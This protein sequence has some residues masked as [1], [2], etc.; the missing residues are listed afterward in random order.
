MTVQGLRVVALTA[1]EKRHALRIMLERERLLS[2]GDI[3]ARLSLDSR[4]TH[5]WLAEEGYQA[6]PLGSRKAAKY[7]QPK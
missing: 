4:T 6:V 5:R 1:T 3:M 7:V 2:L